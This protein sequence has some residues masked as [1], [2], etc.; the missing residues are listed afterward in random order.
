[1]QTAASQ[2][3]T[4]AEKTRKSDFCSSRAITYD[5][6]TEL[7]RMRYRVPVIDPFGAHAYQLSIDEPESK[8]AG[9][10]NVTR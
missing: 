4:L 9:V 8:L 5:V 2:T 7:M 10:L 3:W 1:L 6:S